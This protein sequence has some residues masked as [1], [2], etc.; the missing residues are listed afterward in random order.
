MRDRGI[1][2]YWSDKYTK[3]LLARGFEGTKLFYD[4]AVS[5]EVL[6][7]L[8]DIEEDLSFTFDKADFF[9]F[10]TTLYEQ[11]VPDNNWH[12]Y[13]LN[14]GQHI[15]FFSVKTLEYIAS[16]YALYYASDGK[17]LHV[18]S[19][20]K[21]NKNILFMSKVLAKVPLNFFLRFFLKSKVMTDHYQMVGN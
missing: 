10:S 18:F 11:S 13:G 1:N 7:H 19:S 14:H 15:N 9:V 5:F 21:L 4:V 2:F 3:N 12:Y 8:V 16:K 20:R 17:Q 6:E